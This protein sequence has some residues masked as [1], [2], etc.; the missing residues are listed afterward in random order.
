MNYLKMFKSCFVILVLF[1][2]FTYVVGSSGFYEYK[3]NEKKFLTEER[4][5]Q[6]EEDVDNGV[7][8][9][10]NN[11]VIDTNKDYDNVFTNLSRKISSYINKGFEEAFKYIF[12]YIDSAM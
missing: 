5:K 11:Y 6:F 2:L 3:L 1:F 4:I 7:D 8:I 9:D 12:R 10:I